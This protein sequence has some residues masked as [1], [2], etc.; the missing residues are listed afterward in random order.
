MR[1]AAGEGGDGKP[2]AA[3]VAVFPSAGAGELAGEG[4]SDGGGGHCPPPR[5]EEAA[6][7]ASPSSGVVGEAGAGRTAG[8]EGRERTEEEQEESAFEILKTAS[9]ISRVEL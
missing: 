8:D 9:E 4:E 3:A 6:D 2:V 5:S 7:P 1:P